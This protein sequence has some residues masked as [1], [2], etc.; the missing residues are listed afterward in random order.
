MRGFDRYLF[1]P[2]GRWILIVKADVIHRG[3]WVQYV[4]KSRLIIEDQVPEQWIKITHRFLIA[5]P[6]FPARI[7]KTGPVLHYTTALDV[8]CVM[9][10][11]QTASEMDGCHRTKL[12]FIFTRAS[13]R[14]SAQ[15]S[16]TAA[17][18]NTWAAPTV[19]VCLLPDVMLLFYS[20]D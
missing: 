8:E 14:F 6:V 2:G 15:F 9:T 13:H 11:R 20:S 10:G 18:C 4:I 5:F 7:F 17:W 16:A 12:T 19:W 3:E 1:I